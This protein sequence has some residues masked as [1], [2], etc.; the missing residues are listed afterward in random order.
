MMRTDLP[1]LMR[2]AILAAGVA[3]GTSGVAFGWGAIAVD[4]EYDRHADD[5][6]FGYS[7]GHASEAAARAAAVRECHR[8]D[9][10][11]C[12]VVLTFRTCGAYAVSRRHF[13]VGEGWSVRQA[14][15]AALDT[16]AVSSCRVVVSDCD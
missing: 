8:S 13:G 12:R 5:V 4:D 6:G 7:S 16:C 2:V 11:D 10:E 1:R 15:R 9:N 14:E 3:A